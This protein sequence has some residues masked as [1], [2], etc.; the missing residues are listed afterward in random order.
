MPIARPGDVEDIVVSDQSVSNSRIISLSY[1]TLRGT[2]PWEQVDCARNCGFSHVGLRFHPV[3]DGEVL[4]PV[5]GYPER[6]AATEKRLKDTGVKLL[7]V[8]FFWIKPDTKIRDFAPYLEAAARLGAGNLLAGAADPD[9]SRFTDHWLELCDLAAAHNLRVHL[10]F[11]PL[12][13]LSTIASYA[14]AINLMQT[15]PH[16][17]AAVMIDAIHFF[18]SGS[19]GAEILPEHHAFMRYMQLCDAPAEQPSLKEMERQAREDRLP[20]G[21]GG[22]DLIGLLKALPASL[23]ISVEAPVLTTQKQP[24]RE[25]AKL[26][27]DATRELLARLD[28]T[29]ELLAPQ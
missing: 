12:T 6:I 11:M 5:V 10:E 19:R 22:L 15:A 16:H 14:D 4:L 29:Q 17:A 27:Y 24:P 18:R 3:L 13:N 9:K 8:E 20:P 28:A 1:L 2:P 25:R 23:P 21:R 26:V 7:D